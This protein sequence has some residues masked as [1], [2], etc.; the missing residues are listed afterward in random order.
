MPGMA[1]SLAPPSFP[2]NLEPGG[3]IISRFGAEWACSI[4]R[5]WMA[6]EVVMHGF[7]KKGSSVSSARFVEIDTNGT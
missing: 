2:A 7:S 3:K 5:Q 6:H 4:Y 1:I